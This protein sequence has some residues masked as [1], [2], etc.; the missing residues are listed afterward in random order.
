MNYATV[1]SSLCTFLPKGSQ[2]WEKVLD[3]YDKV[4]KAVDQLR[5]IGD[6]HKIKEDDGLVSCLIGKLHQDYREDWDSFLQER[7][8]Q[9]QCPI[10]DQ[11]MEFLEV[12]NSRAT[13][14]KMREISEKAETSLPSDKKATQQPTQKK[15]HRN[16]SW[17]GG[18]FQS[19]LTLAQISTR[20]DLNKYVADLKKSN[21][22]CP[23]CNKF[24]TFEKNFSS[25]G[26]GRIP[27]HRLSSCPKFLEKTPRERGEFVESLNACF[28]CLDTNH[29][30]KGCRAR[31]KAKC[32]E[33]VN[34]AECGGEH[35]KLLHDCGVTYCHVTATQPYGD[36]KV[37]FEVQELIMP[38][39][40]TSALV[41]FDA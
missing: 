34:G 7:G 21:G 28:V 12:K 38:D 19:N 29:Q 16:E 8:A 20:D 4:G 3:L 13:K 32:S 10:W 24:H 31:I 22:P 14:S 37:L 6:L 11:F 27:T 26:K 36:S 39:R 33:V 40:N 17:S 1:K 41:L 15:N 25:F 18:T 2:K 5:V 30:A 23:C 9:E 35:H